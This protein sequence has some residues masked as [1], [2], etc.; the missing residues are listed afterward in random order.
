[1]SA[2]PVAFKNRESRSRNAA[3]LALPQVRR[4]VETFERRG[5]AYCYWKSS[6]RLPRVLAGKSDLDLLV[7]AG[8]WQ[9]AIATALDMEFKLCPSESDW[10]HPGLL[11]LLSYSDGGGC[12]VHLHL[13]KHIAI[14]DARVKNYVI[15][16]DKSVFEHSV[17]DAASGV[18]LL[19]P[20]SEAVLLAVRAALEVGGLDPLAAR[21]RTAKRREFAMDQRALGG[22]LDRSALLERA[23]ALLGSDLAKSVTE[24]MLADTPIADR[25]DLRRRIRRRLACHR[26]YNAFEA[27]ARSYWRA[28]ID[29][30]GW[31][32][33]ELIHFPRL[34]RRR[35]PGGGCVIAILGVDG[36]GKST[37][38]TQVLNFLQPKMDVMPIYFGTGDGRPSMILWPFKLL[39]PFASRLLGRRPRRASF[40]QSGG[41]PKPAGF[42]FSAML[43]VW[44]IAVAIEKRHKLRSASR[45][46][47]RGLIVI[48]DRFPQDQI[49]DF[50][51][52][53]LL[54]RL[55]AIPEWLRRFESN[56]YALSRKLAP[57]LVI[58]LIARPDTIARREP[59]LHP[60]N[61]PGRIADVLR[62]DF[63]RSRVVCI[64]GQQQLP[65]MIRAIQREVWR[66]I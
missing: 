24:A 59:G 20:A 45:A 22:R 7:G 57:D 54:S 35:A 17:L 13:H 60:A 48:A 62:L 64:D 38:V 40:D 56:S 61:I 43:T 52:G 34:F 51:D 31:A 47:R 19:D 50:N 4:I 8:D 5:I 1:M 27:L 55:T 26:T 41:T 2:R 46:A 12:L 53:P 66:Q 16:L 42:L 28:C 37:S 3:D 25:A 63:P 21:Y 33:S 39:L 14:G 32:S 18:R 58:K 6:R 15:P 36:S 9:R 49:A 23:E 10:A 44:A 65:D 11:S 30:A 29:V